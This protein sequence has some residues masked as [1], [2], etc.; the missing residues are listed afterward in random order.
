MTKAAEAYGMVYAF[1]DSAVRTRLRRIEDPDY[2]PEVPS[3][4]AQWATLQIVGELL[5][6]GFEPDGWQDVYARAIGFSCHGVM[7]EGETCQK[8]GALGWAKKEVD[9]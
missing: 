3:D 7:R 6:M 9:E 4:T 5:E 2:W 1:I 8:C